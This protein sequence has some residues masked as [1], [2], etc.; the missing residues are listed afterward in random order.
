MP[1]IRKLANFN[2]D[3]VLALQQ[4]GSGAKHLRSL[5]TASL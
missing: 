5:K 3:S 2:G 1:G 4:D